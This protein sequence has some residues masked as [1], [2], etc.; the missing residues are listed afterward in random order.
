MITPLNWIMQL[1]ERH[2]ITKTHSFWSSLNQVCFASKNLYNKANYNIRQSLIFC[3]EFP[4]YNLLDKVLKSTSEYR[5]LPAKVAQQTLRNLEQNWSSFFAGIKEYKSYPEKFLGQ[6]KLPKYKDKN[7]RHL[8]IYTAQAVS[9]KSLKKGLLKL[10]GLDFSFPTKIGE[11]KLNQVRVIPKNNYYI[12]EVIYEKEEEKTKEKIEKIASIDLG[13][14]NLIGLTSNQLGFTPILINGRILKSI[15]QFYNLKKAKLQK[16]LPSGQ[17]WSNRLNL[18]TR[19]REEKINNYFHEVSRYL[20][21][22][23]LKS[24]IDTLVIG[25][26]KNWKQKVELGKR[27][28]QNFTNIPHHK[29]REKIKYKCQLV[30]IKVREIEESYT[31]V[32]SFLDLDEIPIYGEKT[33]GEKVKF[34]GKRI[35]RGLYRSGGGKLLNADVNG[36]YNILRKAFPKAFVEGIERCVVHPRLVIPTKQKMKGST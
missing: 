21:N 13:I 26:N 10:S 1:V 9:K 14:N 16:Q 11:E 28:N 31:S 30:G 5:A 34:S 4:H 6:P 23:L 7:G 15:N 22:L 25:K 27:N 32:A 29:L 3:G 17:Y 35:K 18:L 36:S 24:D 20:V 8:V 12:I 2:V 19:K 33:E